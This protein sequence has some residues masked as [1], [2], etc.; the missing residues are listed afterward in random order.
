MHSTKSEILAQLKRNGSASVDELATGLGLAPMTVRQH[1]MAL[2]RDALIQAVEVRR[3]NG[4]PHYRYTLTED[5]HRRIADGHDRLLV[6]LVE[7]AGV[8]EVNG[9]GPDVRRARLFEAAATAL[10][11]RV[12]HE[13]E[14]LSPDQRM[15]RIIALLRSHGGFADWHPLDDGYEVRDFG[16]VY[17]EAVGGGGPCAWHE[18]LLAALTGAPVRTVAPPDGCGECCRYIIDMA[19]AGQAAPTGRGIS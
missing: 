16:C 4:R 12:R 15:D 3:G 2:E 6:L 17:R 13:L 14:P 11:S 1:L 18:T 8:I 19:P 7:Q 5:G 9:E 10:A